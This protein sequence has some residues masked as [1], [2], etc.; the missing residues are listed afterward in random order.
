MD[1]EKMYEEVYECLDGNID[2]AVELAKMFDYDWN[3]PYDGIDDLFRRYFGGDL[4]EIIGAFLENDINVGGYET[5]YVDENGFNVRLYTEWDVADLVENHIDDVASSIVHEVENGNLYF[6]KDEVSDELMEILD[7]KPCHEDIVDT[8]HKELDKM[9]SSDA[10]G[11]EKCI[12]TITTC[13]YATEA[14]NYIVDVYLVG[15]KLDAE[16]YNKINWEG[17]LER[18]VMLYRESGYQGGVS[19]KKYTEMFMAKMLEEVR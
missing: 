14:F 9:L 12:D 5:Y 19:I 1:Y 2:E 7:P 16:Y 8:L 6:L 13:F 4:V 11:G 15:G 3:T 18:L 17:F 10:F